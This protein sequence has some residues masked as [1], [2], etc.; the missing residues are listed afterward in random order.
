VP[1]RRMKKA[2]PILIED[3]GSV[4]PAESERAD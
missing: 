2:R 1:A 4:D 3:E